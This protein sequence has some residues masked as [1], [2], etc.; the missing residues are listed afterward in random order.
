M[1]KEEQGELVWSDGGEEEERML[2]RRMETEWIEHVRCCCAHARIGLTLRSL[3]SSGGQVL[4]TG[5]LMRIL[6]YAFDRKYPPAT[7]TTT[8]TTTAAASAAAAFSSA[9][10]SSAAHRDK[11]DNA[12]KDNTEGHASAPNPAPSLVDS[13]GCAM[14]FSDEYL[15]S[16]VAT[17]RAPGKLGWGGEH[18]VG[19]CSGWNGRLALLSFSMA[20][21]LS[22][23]VWL[24]RETVE[25][26]LAVSEIRGE[27]GCEWLHGYCEF[28]R[29]WYQYWP[30][31]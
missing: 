12:K 14:C 4:E 6:E 7:T 31:K 11:R 15:L 22:R 24:G 25:R 3:S 9:A 28:L 8:T 18:N 2:F 17:T 16:C 27:D 19:R 23:Q 1:E 20:H 10:A 21:S 30:L 29:N 26:L 13:L 5:V